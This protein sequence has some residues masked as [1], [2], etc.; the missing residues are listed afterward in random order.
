MGMY[1]NYELKKSAGDKRIRGIVTNFLARKGYG[2]IQGE[3][4]IKFFVHFSDIR[5]TDY[6]TLVQGEE[7]EFTSHK[8]DKGFQALDVVRLNPPLKDDPPPIMGDRKT[9]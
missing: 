5:S 4:G 8:S 2:F 9:W 7:V 3:D 1:L 6:R